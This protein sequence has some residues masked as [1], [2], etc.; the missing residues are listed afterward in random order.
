[1]YVVDQET[2]AGGSR[3]RFSP[4]KMVA[5][6][7]SA[8]QGPA[9]PE[10]PQPALVAAP[11]AP[12]FEPHVEAPGA[13]SGESFLAI[14]NAMLA[15]DDETALEP[16]ATAFDLVGLIG[17]AHDA[18]APEAAGRGV[19]LALAVAPG[20]PGVYQGDVGRLR[21]ALLNLISGALK[22]TTEDSLE[23]TV[24]WEAGTLTLRVAGAEAAAAMVR[25]LTDKTQPGPRRPTAQRLALARTAV[26]S[27]GGDVQATPGDGVEAIIPL[28]RLAEARSVAPVA[29]RVAEPARP[30][31]MFAP[32]LRILVAEANAAHQQVLTTLLAGMGLEPVVVSDGQDVV[33]AWREQ[34]WDVLLIDIEGDAI[35]GRSVARSIRGAETVARWPRM[36]MLA[37]AANVKARDL[38]DSFTAVIDGLV[39]KPIHAASLHA[40]IAT[41]L[42]AETAAPTMRV[43]L[44]A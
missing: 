1:M 5:R 12:L 3:A 21:Q 7:L 16:D 8:L 19:T 25:V 43:S 13:A 26:T 9:E 20:T 30:L 44:G 17:E 34:G 24:A 28:A 40:A 2:G 39:A 18:F 36:P 41:A 42:N 38:D 22:A 10:A 31:P 35:C 4:L 23:V 33:K 14:V 37:L 32:G 6:A 27:L 15:L 11:I 29:E